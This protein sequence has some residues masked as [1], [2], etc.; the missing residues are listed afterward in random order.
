[1]CKSCNFVHNLFQVFGIQMIQSFKYFQ[2]KDS[3]RFYF[4]RSLTRFVW[5]LIIITG[6]VVVSVSSC[7]FSIFFNKF[8]ITEMPHKRTVI[9]L[10]R[11][12]LFRRTF[13]SLKPMYFWILLIAFS[14]LL[15][16]LQRSEICLLNDSALSISIPSSFISFQS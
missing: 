11:T 5:K 12:K 14:W 13:F 2:R 6:R 7:I 8:W 1:M 16:F 9:E 10:D 15:A 3:E 4:N